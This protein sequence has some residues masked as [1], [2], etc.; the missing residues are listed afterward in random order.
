V[1]DG[2]IALAPPDSDRDYPHALVDLV[3]AVE[4][5][6]FWFAARTDVILSALQRMPRGA[7]ATRALDIGCGNGFVMAALERAGLSMSGIDMHWSALIRARSRVRGS[8]YCSTASPLPFFADFSLVTLCDVIEHVEDDAQVLAD[9]ARVLVPGGFAIVTVPAGPA[10]WSA[11]DE[12]IGHKRRYDREALVATLARA[13]FEVRFVRYFNFP[14]IL[15]AMARRLTGRRRAAD[16]GSGLPIVREALRVPP[17]P[18]NAMLRWA[19]RAEGPLRRLA[20]MRGGSLIALA[21]RRD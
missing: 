1:R 2:I 19:I 21:Q 6:H 17:P 14:L 4:D 12:V 3:S 5:R 15:A 16:A 8:L 9:A 13:N 11:Y 20:W 7:D 18:L 10:L